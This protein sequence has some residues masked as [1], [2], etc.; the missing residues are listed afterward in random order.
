ML[1]ATGS[2]LTVTATEDAAVPQ[3]L[4]TAYDMVA[5]PAAIPLTT[6]KGFTVA[7]LVAV[8]LHTPLIVTSES[9]IV[10]PAQT[11]LAPVMAPATGSGLTVTTTEN[12]AVPQLLD[13]V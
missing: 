1:P 11:A 12:A 2:G 6:P 8:E 9:D 10:E 7:I 4:V 5:V 3:L 13:S